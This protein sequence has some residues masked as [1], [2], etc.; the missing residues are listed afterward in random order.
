M[1]ILCYARK[2]K[3]PENAQ[4]TVR[5]VLTYARDSRPLQER[6]VAHAV[7]V[8]IPTRC[9]RFIR[10]GLQQKADGKLNVAIHLLQGSNCFFPCKT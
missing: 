2:L 5:L 10:L 6:P 1:K 4:Q 9:A 3:I 8:S 7:I